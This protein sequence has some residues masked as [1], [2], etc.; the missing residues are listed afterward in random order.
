MVNGEA[1][2]PDNKPQRRGHRERQTSEL[3]RLLAESRE[4]PTGDGHTGPRTPST[5]VRESHERSSAT[6]TL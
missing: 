2:G 4:I 5:A 1:E 6:T 3:T